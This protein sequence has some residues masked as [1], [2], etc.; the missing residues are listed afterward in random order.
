MAD[1]RHLE[2]SKNGYT[3]RPIEQLIDSKIKTE[4]QRS[5]STRTTVSSRPHLHATLRPYLFA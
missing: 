5:L 2:K 3:I 4:N 1:G